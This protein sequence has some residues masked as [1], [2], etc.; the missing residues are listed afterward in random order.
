[1]FNS[2]EGLPQAN[3]AL[4]C[5]PND[6]AL[7]HLVLLTSNQDSAGHNI[8]VAYRLTLSSTCRPIAQSDVG[9]KCKPKQTINGNIR[10]NIHHSSPSQIFGR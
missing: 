3:E 10:A 1:M 5:D 9:L 7:D 6:E 4:K 2:H 8:G